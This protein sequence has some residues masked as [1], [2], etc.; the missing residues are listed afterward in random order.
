M[1][2]TI[3]FLTLPVIFANIYG[4]TSYALQT[5]PTINMVLYF[6]PFWGN[7]NILA[8]RPIP[9]SLTSFTIKLGRYTTNN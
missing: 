5:I 2:I 3:S 4:Q 9:L 6:G 8:K 1:Q 7:E